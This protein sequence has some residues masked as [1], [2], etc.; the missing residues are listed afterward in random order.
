MDNEIYDEQGEYDSLK[1][2]RFTAT[3]AGKYMVIGT[4]TFNSGIAG[5]EFDI[6]INKNGVNTIT[7]KCKWI[8]STKQSEQVTTII[9]LDANDY[10]E[11]W[12]YQNSGVSLELGCRTYTGLQVNKI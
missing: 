4:I 3:K 8:N 1:N 7:K 2:Y 9:D 12:T 5:K 11:L 6:I 10:L